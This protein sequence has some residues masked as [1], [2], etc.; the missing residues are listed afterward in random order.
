LFGGTNG[1]LYNQGEVFA[2]L[3]RFVDQEQ[4]GLAA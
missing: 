1:Y 3:E 4:R 2:D